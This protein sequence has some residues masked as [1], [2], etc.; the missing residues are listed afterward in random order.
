MTVENTQNKMPPLQMGTTNEY[1]FTFAVLLQDPTEEEAFEAI[2]ASVLQADGTEI[3]LVYNT[4]YTV[5]LNTDRIGGTLTV[6]DIRT[7]GDYITIYRQYAQTQEVD[8]KD[9]NSAPAETFEQCF[10]KLTM[11][12]QQQQEEINRSIKLPVSSDITNLSLP[13][14]IA[15]RTLKWNESE[16][17]LINSDVS[18]DEIDDSVQAALEASINAKQQ[19]E[20]ASDAAKEVV[21]KVS[22]VD[23][24]WSE[25]VE[26]NMFKLQIF[27]TVVKDHILTYEESKGLALQG[28]YVY[29]TAIA[30]VRL[31]YPD[32]Y[33]QV[34]KEYNESTETETV[35]EVTVKVNSNGHKF[36]DIA[37][38]TAIDE[39]YNSLGSAWFYGVDTENERIF[40]PRDKYFAVNGVAPVVGN[41]MTLGFTD[42]TNNAGLS[43]NSESVGYLGKQG[44][45]TSVGTTQVTDSL[46]SRIT[47]GIT[48][49]PTKSGI[50]AHL[51]ANKDKYLYICVGNTE[52]VSSVTDVIDATTT[53]NDTVPLFTGQY[54]D[55]K[56]NNL[57]WLKGGEQVN[58]AG[59]YATCYNELVN[60][61][62]GETKYGDLKVVDTADMIVGI[63]Y[64][65][66][67]KV[68]QEDMT[69]TTPTAISN[70]ALSGAVSGN[71]KAL[72]LTNG[73]QTGALSACG[74]SA[75][76]NVAGFL[77]PVNGADGINIGDTAETT[78]ATMFYTDKAI[79]IVSDPTKSGIIAEQSTSQLY[80]KVA[81]AVQNLEL[82]DVGKV[83]E[84]VA[85]KISHQDCKAYITE[86]YK[87]GTSWYR[88]YSDGWCEQ[89]GISNV[90]NTGTVVNLLKPF[91]DTNYTIQVTSRFGAASAGATVNVWGVSTTVST[92][93]LGS[94]TNAANPVQW[95]ASGYIR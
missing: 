60:V 81:N 19:A 34:V 79:G 48:T 78:A 36:Y 80:F 63:D 62:N 12:S 23:N 43:A 8:Y 88:V 9:F 26:G 85:D 38:K 93:T 95:Q 73:T 54:F 28:T 45:G 44:Y 29:K 49:D 65:E 72:M 55:F 39:F 18:I 50:E 6:N 92:M 69:F 25:I 83:M 14:P 90:V 32:F 71:G 58:N 82:L 52:S 21:E 70:K 61:L 56:P 11:L 51:T 87:N 66:Y 75:S 64:S 37:D 59:I 68:N 2:K 31:G 7:S 35:N 47:V 3:E 17:G 91:K 20:I 13:N 5:T 16:T 57:S 84:A 94:G 86:T 53:E 27:D 41:G 77:R 89:G 40:L 46:A 22:E 15:G 33:A 74:S 4:D 30:G 42:G 1:P 10:D 76:G 24:I 67:W